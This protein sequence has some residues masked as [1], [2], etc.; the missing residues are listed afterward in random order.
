MI[1]N[2]S[3]NLSLNFNLSVH[4]EIQIQNIYIFAI[5]LIENRRAK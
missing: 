1:K 3:S 4:L 5:Y 2:T